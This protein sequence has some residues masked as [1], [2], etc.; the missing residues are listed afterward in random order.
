MGVLV[1]GSLVL[2][3]QTVVP[4]VGMRGTTWL[5]QGRYLFPGVFALAV[6]A[7]WGWRHLIPSKWDRWATVVA[8]GVLVAFDVLCLG[9]VIIP[10]YRS[11]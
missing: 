11:V 9:L 1:V 6:L 7:A 4:M 3:L 5:P 8:L 2:I 10:Y